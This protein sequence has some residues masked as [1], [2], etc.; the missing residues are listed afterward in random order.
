[1]NEVPGAVARA[2]RRE[3]LH[4]LIAQAT[5]ELIELDA[6]DARARALA[7]TAP[8][9]HELELVKYADRT[10]RAARVRAWAR[11][12]GWPLVSKQGPLPKAVEAAYTAAN[13]DDPKETTSSATPGDGPE[14]DE[15]GGPAGTDRYQ[16]T[17]EFPETWEGSPS[18]SADAG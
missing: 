9:P 4:A 8:E 6:A 3:R 5:S 14:P 11:E 15:E 7:P 16:T 12:N 18:A 13:A 2:K 10:T 17:T 1:M